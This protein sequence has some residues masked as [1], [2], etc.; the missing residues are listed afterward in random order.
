MIAVA[1][2]IAL[3][4]VTDAVLAGLLTGAVTGL[5]IPIGDRVSGNSGYLKLS[6]QSVRYRK[7]YVRLSISYLIRIEIDGKYLLLRGRRIPN[8]FQPAGGVYKFNQTIRDRFNSWGVLSDNLIPIDD[9]S[10]D[11]LRI[12]IRGQY[13]PRFMK[14][15]DSGKNRE[16]GIW[17][18]FSEELIDTGI[19][20]AE[21]FKS[22]KF[23]FVRKHVDSLQY[24]EYSNG[25]EMLVAHVF[26]L[27]PTA[28]QVQE[29]RALKQRGGTDAAQWCSEDRIR[30]RGVEP[31]ES[32]TYSVSRTAEW[33]LS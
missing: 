17:R 22:I 31:G 7:R 16:V 5:I 13:L 1:S 15:F 12:R 23:D 28:G 24:S 14:W 21:N 29:L 10:A 33:L 27:L 11:D 9:V 32:Y 18:E 26:E 30:R 25:L 19:L 8:Q 3:F 2:V 4:F 20:S 6:A